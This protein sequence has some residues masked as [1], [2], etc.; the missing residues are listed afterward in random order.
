VATAA[1]LLALALPLSSLAADPAAVP[2]SVRDLTLTVHARRLL[3]EDPVLSPLNL[4]VSIKGNVARLWGLVPTEDLRT[5]AGKKI[6]KMPG[7]FFVRNEITVGT[8]SPDPL[9]LHPDGPTQSASASPDRG[10]GSLAVLASRSPGAL[11]PSVRE[12]SQELAPQGIALLPP[13]ALGR[14]G[15]DHNP[16]ADAGPDAVDAAIERIRT[17]EPRFRAVPILRRDASVILHASPDQG[18]LAMALARE[19]A[20]VPGIESVHIQPVRPG[21]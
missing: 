14:K 4:N 19:L 20:R 9:Q 15:S 8:R 6:Q 3:L 13:V 10:T 7:V 12:G 16:E 18:E 2:P 5:M 21:K 1:L 17:A 11:D